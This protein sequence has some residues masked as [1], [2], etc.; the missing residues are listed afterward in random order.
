M[1]KYLYDERRDQHHLSNSGK[2]SR[3]QLLTSAKKFSFL[4]YFNILFSWVCVSNVAWAGFDNKNRGKNFYVTFAKKHRSGFDYIQL[5]AC[6]NN[7]HFLHALMSTL[8]KYCT[9]PIYLL[10]QLSYTARNIDGLH[11]LFR[12]L[13]VI[14]NIYII[15][16]RN[17][18]RFCKDHNDDR[19]LIFIGVVYSN[20]MLLFLRVKVSVYEIGWKKWYSHTS[21][22]AYFCCNILCTHRMY[23]EE[24]H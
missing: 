3:R 24:N 20:I 21:W 23:F 8:M 9:F 15:Y 16:F 7:V 10:T 14:L 19:N 18:F 4:F 13:R 5:S 17:F 6:E 1:M 11:V 12:K 2:R 22:C